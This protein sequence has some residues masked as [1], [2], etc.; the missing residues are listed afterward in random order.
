MGP[1]RRPEGGFGLRARLD[2]AGAHHRGSWR[3]ARRCPW[4]S[5]T[6]TTS[7]RVRPRRHRPHPPR[8]GSRGWTGPWPSRSCSTQDGEHEARFVREA[9]LTARLQ[10]PS[11][12]PVYEA[13]RWPTGEPFY[14]MKLVAGRSLAEVIA[15]AKTLAG[16]PGAAAPRARGGRGHRL[17]AHASASSTAISSPPTCSSAPSARRWSSTGGSPR[18]SRASASPPSPASRVPLPR[19]SDGP[20]DPWRARSWGRR[21]T[22][23]RSRPRASPWTSAPTSTRSAPSSTTCSA[24]TPP[25][26]GGTSAQVIDA[27]GRGPARAARASA[28]RACPADLLAIV[29]RPWRA[30]RPSAT[31]RRASWPRICGASRQG[32][33]SAR[34][35]TRCGSGSWRFI[36]RYRAAVAVT[37]VAL[38]VLLGVG[39][40]E[41]S[42]A[43]W[44][45]GSR[46][47]Q[48]GRGRG[49]PAR[50]G[51]RAATD[52]RTRR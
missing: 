17:R 11:I 14:A 4:S 10:H 40:G 28:R 3:A 32:R 19:P 13:G 23:R 48:A 30:T 51:E 31:P 26:D 45:A 41:R 22:C 12:V 9:L 8:P 15:E 52:A 37:A 1:A 50:R 47:A 39:D 29:P 38:L 46:R 33:S 43:S 7:R 20:P 25:Y 36:R 2:A 18:I 35:R 5:P 49:G 44:R 27:G 42:G 21:R 24:G 16:A 6:A 34:T